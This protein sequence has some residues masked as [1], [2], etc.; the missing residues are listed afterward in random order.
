MDKENLIIKIQKDI[1]EAEAMLKE[2]KDELQK[3]QDTLFCLR[4]EANTLI[5]EANSLPNGVNDAN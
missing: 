5:E 2:A 1:V 4:V 3:Q